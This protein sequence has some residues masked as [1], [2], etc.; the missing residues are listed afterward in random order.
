MPR[1]VLDLTKTVEENASDYFEKAK[2]IKK[3][4]KGAELALLQHI[5]KLNEMEAKQEKSDVEESKKS[6]VQQRKK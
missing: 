1:L 3:K 5:R 2:K 6:A 4:I